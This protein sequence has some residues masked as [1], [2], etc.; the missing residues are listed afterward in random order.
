MTPK[1]SYCKISRENKFGVTKAENCEM[2]VF[3]TFDYTIC[4]GSTPTFLYFDLYL[5][6]AYAAH[7]R[8]CISLKK[9]AAIVAESRTRS[10]VLQRLQAS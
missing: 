4:I 3:E 6:S 7:Y 8:T 10:Y 5:Y 1:R 2:E 9:V